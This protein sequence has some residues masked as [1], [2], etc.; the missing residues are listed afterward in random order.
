M[1][2]TDGIPTFAMTDEIVF[3]AE[4]LNIDYDNLGVIRVKVER[5]DIDGIE[6][7][8]ITFEDTRGSFPETP[9]NLSF[10]VTEA[11]AQKLAMELNGSLG[12]MTYS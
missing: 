6:A 3:P 9:D 5:T 8:R 1:I 11:G 12:W 7:R 4:A 10:L 2:H